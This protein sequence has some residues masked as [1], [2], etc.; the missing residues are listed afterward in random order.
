MSISL[1]I[2]STSQGRHGEIYIASLHP[3]VTRPMKMEL[4]K[5]TSEEAAAATMQA[6]AACADDGRIPGY[7][8]P[9][10]DAHRSVVI[11][12]PL[13]MQIQQD[14]RYGLS[15]QGIRHR[16]FEDLFGDLHGDFER[17]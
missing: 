2:P 9:L 3:Q 13:V 14:I 1:T 17:Y 12:E 15:K 16:T 8:Y 10:L 5:A 11:D 6:L 7:P 4:P